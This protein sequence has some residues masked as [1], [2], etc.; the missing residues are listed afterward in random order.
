[1]IQAQEEH[2]NCTQKDTSWLLGLKKTPDK[3]SHAHTDSYTQQ[4]R[5]FKFTIIVTSRHFKVKT[6]VCK[7]ENPNNQMS[8]SEQALGNSWKEKLFFFNRKKQKQTS[9][10]PGSGRGSHLSGLGEGLGKREGKRGEERI[11]ETVGER[12]NF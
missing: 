4:L 12:R 6:L 2:T 11:T 3:H 9:D 1:M 7:S 8:P 5:T 10:S